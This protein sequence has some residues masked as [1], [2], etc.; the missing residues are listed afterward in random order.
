MLCT[1]D[2]T[3]FMRKVNVKSIFSWL[4]IIRSMSSKLAL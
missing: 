2:L 1:L 3:E 4:R